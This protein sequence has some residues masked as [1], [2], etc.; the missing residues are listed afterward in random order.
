MRKLFTGLIVII[1]LLVAAG[2]ILP[3][4]IPASVYKDRITAQVSST[5]GRDVQ[6]AGDVKLSVF[7]T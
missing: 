7:P 3:G 1:V 2:L 5:L 4:L 6:I